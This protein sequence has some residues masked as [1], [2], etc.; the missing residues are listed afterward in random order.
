MTMADMLFVDALKQSGIQYDFNKRRIYPLFQDIQLDLAAH[1]SVT[2]PEFLEKFKKIVHANYKYCLQ[3]DD[4]A[5]RNLLK[6]TGATDNNLTRFKEKFMPFFVEDFRWTEHNYDNMIKRSEEFSRWW[7]DVTPLRTMPNVPLESIDDFLQELER[8]NA[9]VFSLPEQEFVDLV[10]EIFFERNVRPVLISKTPL[11]STSELLFR[12]FSRWLIGQLA[13]C[14]KFH[15]V[16][17]VNA[18]REK[19]IQDL[20]Q[21]RGKETFNLEILNAIR[22][23]YES[24]LALLVQRNLITKD[25]ERTFAEVYPLFDPLYVS[26][27]KNLSE[28]EDLASVSK[29]IFSLDTHCNKQLDLAAQVVGR[30]FSQAESSFL[31]SVYQLMELGSGQL[32]DGLFVTRPGVVV[33]GLADSTVTFYTFGVSVEG[34]IGLSR[35][36]TQSSHLPSEGVNINLFKVTGRDTLGQRRMIAQLLRSRTQYELLWNPAQRWEDGSKLFNLTAPACKTTCAKLTVPLAHLEKLSAESSELQAVKASLEAF[37]KL[38]QPKQ[39]TVL[40]QNQAFLHSQAT[41]LDLLV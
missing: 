32:L 22:K 21:H 9:D 40:A 38:S 25:D 1:Q 27:D 39:T 36:A 18:L 2:E 5:Y 15:F 8:H 12:A 37:Q 19:M 20:T 41:I 30:T 31:R 11:P 13:I 33:S 6:L 7:N 10:F 16:P 3:G 23:D 24:L 28:Y 34:F 35:V 17:E 26:Y 29:R 4:G 14:A